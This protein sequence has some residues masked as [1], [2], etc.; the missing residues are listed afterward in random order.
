[1]KGHGVAEAG[2]SGDER[3]KSRAI[4]RSVRTHWSRQIILQLTQRRFAGTK[5][6]R[7]VPIEI[8][9]RKIRWIAGEGRGARIALITGPD[10]LVREAPR[11]VRRYIEGKDAAGRA[12]L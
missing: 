1:L 11:T 4:V 6:A 9:A 5:R 2:V 3:C 8:D 10:V 7:P 12:V